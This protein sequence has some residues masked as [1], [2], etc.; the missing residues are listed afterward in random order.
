MNQNFGAG[1]RENKRKKE[2]KLAGV[3]LF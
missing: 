2:E 3:V 1:G